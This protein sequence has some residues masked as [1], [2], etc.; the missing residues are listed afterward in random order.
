[1]HN[2]QK[3]TKTLKIYSKKSFASINDKIYIVFQS[4]KE[5]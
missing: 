1:M 5:L 2:K 4:C 3:F